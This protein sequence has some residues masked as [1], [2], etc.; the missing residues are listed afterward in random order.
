MMGRK[1]KLG[2]GNLSRVWKDSIEGLPTLN[3][4]FP[5][6]FEICTDQDCTVQNF[7]R[8]ETLTFFRRRLCPDLREQ[9]DRVRQYIWGLNTTAEEDVV[10][11][12]LSKNAKY[13]TKSMYNWLEKP[14]HGNNYR[15]I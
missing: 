6:L 14:L 8:V 3:L 2:C 11:W 4:R 13:S 15:W 10:F 9:W 12:G 7:N 1:I 5:R